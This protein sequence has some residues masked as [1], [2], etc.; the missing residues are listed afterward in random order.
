MAKARY[1]IQAFLTNGESELWLWSKVSNNI[2]TNMGSEARFA[3]YENG[4]YMEDYATEAEA[5]QAIKDCRY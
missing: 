3:V 4:E 2:A 1:T 5:R